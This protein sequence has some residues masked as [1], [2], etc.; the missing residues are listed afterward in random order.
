MFSATSKFKIADR[1]HFVQHGGLLYSLDNILPPNE[2]KAIQA[3]VEA[4]Q[5]LLT[6]TAD[7]DETMTDQADHA[8][9]LLLMAELK[10]QVIMRLCLYEISVPRTEMGVLLHAIL[11]LPDLIMRWNHVRNFWCFF[12]E[13]MLGWLKGF[14]HDRHHATENLVNSYSRITFIRR[15]SSAQ[16]A[17]VRDMY[18]ASGMVLPSRSFVATADTRLQAKQASTRAG[19]VRVCACVCVV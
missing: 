3:A 7:V 9:L 10:L 12:N 14:V 6:A 1:I 19:P 18:A 15:A 16:R 8:R 11:H 13:R 2:Y 17:R 4:L 5:M